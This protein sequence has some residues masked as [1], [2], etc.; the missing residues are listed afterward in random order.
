MTNADPRVRASIFWLR[1]SATAHANTSLAQWAGPE[2]WNQE[3]PG[4]IPGPGPFTRIL[5]LHK[6]NLDLI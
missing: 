5:I 4:S 6:E 3:V 2:A 1:K